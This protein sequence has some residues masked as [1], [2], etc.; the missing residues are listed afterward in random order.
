MA[1]PQDQINNNIAIGSQIREGLEFTVDNTLDFKLDTWLYKP[2]REILGVSLGANPGTNARLDSTTTIYKVVEEHT[3]ST[4]RD[5]MANENTDIKY[6]NPDTH[7]QLEVPINQGITNAQKTTLSEFLTDEQTGNQLTPTY[8]VVQR[9]VSQYSKKLSEVIGKWLDVKIHHMLFNQEYAVKAT[10]GTTSIQSSQRKLSYDAISSV[11]TLSSYRDLYK[12]KRKLIY[13]ELIGRNSNE[14][15]GILLVHSQLLETWKQEF[16]DDGKFNTMTSS[17]RQQ[18]VEMYET[19]T[20]FKFPNSRISIIALPY[21]LEA[22]ILNEAVDKYQAK[23]ISKEAI[24]QINMLSNVVDDV[25]RYQEYIPYNGN[26]L[27]RQ[28]V[29]GSGD[30]GMT[31]VS[32][33]LSNEGKLAPFFS[34][35]AGVRFTLRPNQPKRAVHTF[36]VDNIKISSNSQE[37]QA[38]ILESTDK[39]AELNSRFAIV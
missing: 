13:S 3:P 26:V 1:F 28:M 11:E 14:D 27:T 5:I 12:I 35:Y 33:Y 19:D 22:L 31:I 21:H 36:D 2:I 15:L 30:A 8:S 16:K 25:Q 7:F 10:N 24:F 17:E 20:I 18:Y 6:D 9:R 4:F 38:M 34:W 39:Y 29:S 37:L 23:F 32:E